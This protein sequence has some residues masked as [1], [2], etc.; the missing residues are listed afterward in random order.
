[1]AEA[2]QGVLVGIMRAMCI[3]AHPDDVE[4]GMGATVAGLT[5]RG[6]EVTIVDLTDGEPTP[7][8]DSVTRA[9]EAAEAAEVLGVSRRVL[10]EG[11]NRWL[12]PTVDLR[13]SLASVIRG[14]RP[15][16]L[17][18]PYPEDAHPDHAVAHELCVAA[19]FAAKLTKT[20]MPGEPW[21][22]PRIYRYAAVHRKTDAPASFL[23]DATSTLPRKLEA[24]CRYR[25]QFFDNPSNR[26][27]LELV[28][29]RARY[30]GD[31]AGTEAAEPFFAFEPPVLAQP[32]LLL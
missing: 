30:F 17:F 25:S 24:L 12:E 5:S 8:G 4:I 3:G 10:L 19:R 13:R 14:V 7:M 26:G 32:E 1:M 29:R 2:F 28:E 11:T 15:D 27:V 31:L 18:I 21:Y 22:V 6:V 9:R 16:V 23:V 20:D